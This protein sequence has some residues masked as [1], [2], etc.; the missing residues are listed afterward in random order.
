[1]STFIK[2]VSKNMF[3]NCCLELSELLKQQC[4]LGRYTWLLMEMLCFRMQ[5]VYIS[6]CTAPSRSQ[7][8][9]LQSPVFFSLLQGSRES[10]T[11]YN[12][13]E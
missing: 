6:L 13:P 12:L 7:K 11:C 8:G 10:M 4:T 5:P 3:R 2:A 1:M 9:E